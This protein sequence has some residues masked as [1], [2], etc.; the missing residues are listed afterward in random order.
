MKAFL[1]GDSP[2]FSAGQ[3]EGF[4]SS[5]NMHVKVS[6][7]LFNS[8]LRYWVYEYLRR[9]PKGKKYRALIIRFIKDRNASLLLIDVSICRLTVTL[10]NCRTTLVF[11]SWLYL[12]VGYQVFARVSTRLRV[13]DELEVRVEEADPRNDILSLKEPCSLSLSISTKLAKG[14]DH[15]FAFLPPLQNARV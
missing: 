10:Y 11:T 12:Q 1:R 7:R 5:V 2:P 3:L 6:K 8:S 14:S 9:Q 13:G 15:S 4:G